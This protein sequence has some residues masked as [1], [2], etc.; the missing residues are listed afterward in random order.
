MPQTSFSARVRDGQNSARVQPD[1]TDD[2]LLQLAL[3]YLDQQ[4]LHNWDANGLFNAAP[5]QQQRNAAQNKTV[6]RRKPPLDKPEQDWA[7][8]QDALFGGTIEHEEAALASAIQEAEAEAQ[9][10][11][12]GMSEDMEKMVRELQHALDL[13]HAKLV[14]SRESET[15]M[16]KRL[17][18]EAEELNAL[19]A[20]RERAEQDAKRAREEAARAARLKRRQAMLRGGGRRRPQAGLQVGLDDDD[21]GED[22]LAQD[23]GA[24]FNQLVSKITPA[25]EASLS[26]IRIA[27]WALYSEKV[28]IAPSRDSD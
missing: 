14:R 12:P 17:K 18:E 23:E 13:T 9:R 4:G 25:I 10:L 19:R 27:I 3:N 21:D 24:Y 7:R 8:D 22:I 2:D 16:G 28:A 11:A 1:Q 6:R 15:Q 5:N 20:E 26:A